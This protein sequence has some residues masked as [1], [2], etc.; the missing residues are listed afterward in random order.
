MLGQFA[1]DV[2]DGVLAVFPPCNA[3]LAIPHRAL[4]LQV[5]PL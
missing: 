2:N 3:G 5:L 4:V 1:L